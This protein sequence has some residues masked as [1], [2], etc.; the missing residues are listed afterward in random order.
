VHLP[1]FLATAGW[2]LSVDVQPDAHVRLRLTAGGP[3][4]PQAGDIRIEVR[5]NGNLVGGMTYRLDPDLTDP[6]ELTG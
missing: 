3:F 1:E 6:T 4:T 5:A 2:Q